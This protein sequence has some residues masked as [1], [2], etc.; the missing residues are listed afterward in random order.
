MQ[1]LGGLYFVSIMK[2]LKKDFLLQKLDFLKSHKHHFY[3]K[4]NITIAVSVIL[5]F[6]IL[7][8][9][10][11]LRFI[12]TDDA[13]INSHIMQ[14]AARVSGQVATINVENNQQVVAGQLLFSLDRQPFI[15]AADKTRA[16]LAV[17]NANLSNAKLRVD[18][19][20]KLVKLRAIPIEER[21]NAVTNFE[22]AS[23]SVGLAKAN[24]AEAELN[25]G[26]T[27]VTAPAN[28]TVTELSLRQGNIVTANQPLFVI[29]GEAKYWVDANFKET[30]LAHI[31]PGQ[32][33]K[34]YVDMYPHHTFQG[35]VES[36]SSGSGAAFSLLPPENA[37][38]NWVKVTQR[39]TVRIHILDPDPHFPLRVGTTATVSINTKSYLK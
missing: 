9:L 35:V 5:V 25:L 21:D 29:V 26:Y 8:W 3:D 17:A 14:I 12:S 36:I 4:K 39:V 2:L 38:G 37:S 13:Y 24:L 11:N 30:E 20:L 34:V 1:D 18:R 27:Q 7:L 33:A 31:R 6:G 22:S 10:Y 16:Q 32:N 23:A 15:V 19:A 28:G